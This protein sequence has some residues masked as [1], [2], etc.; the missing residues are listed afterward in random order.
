MKNKS[1]TATRLSFC[2]P[3]GR[4]EETCNRPIFGEAQGEFLR[5]SSREYRTRDK[6]RN[7]FWAW[8]HAPQIP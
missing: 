1:M 5:V 6:N 4:V 7:W 2:E 8:T 3:V